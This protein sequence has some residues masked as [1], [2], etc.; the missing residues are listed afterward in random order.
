M[1]TRSNIIVKK[2]RSLALHLFHHLENNGNIDFA[3]NGERRFTENLFS[4]LAKAAHGRVVLFDIGA[5]VG[6]YTEM[7]L[8][9][10]GGLTQ[11]VEIH[12]FEPTRACFDILKGKF[13]AS[14]GV[15]LNDNAV[16]KASGTA[17]IF[18]DISGSKLASLERRNLDAYSIRLERSETVKTVRLDEYLDKKGIGHV[19]FMKIDIEGHEVAAFEGMGK[20]FNGEIVDFIQFEYGGANLDSHTSLMELYALFDKAGFV[21]AKIMRDGL[22]IR[23]YRPWMDN[24]QYANYVAISRRIVDSLS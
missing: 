8:E 16:S 9:N 2:L 4:Y 7:L 23:E 20:Y 18:Y 24:F 22:E 21:V 5:N 3:A 12:V 14:G 1:I 19:H 10:G 11:G 13:S 15:V 6:E 17:E